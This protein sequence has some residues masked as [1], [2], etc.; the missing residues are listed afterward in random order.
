M[1]RRDLLLTGL[2][3]CALPAYAAQRRYGIGPKGAEISY[4]FQLQGSPVTGRVPLSSADLRIDPQDLTNS[5]A[6]VRADIRRARTGL[7]FAT[8]ALKS[9][10]VL[11]ANRF[12]EARFTSTRVRLGAD[13]R[14]SGGASLEGQL[15]LRGVKRQ[16]RLSANIYRPRGAAPDDLTNLTVLL[17]GRLDRTD[18]GA[19]GYPDLVAKTVTLEIRADIA[20]T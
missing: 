17:T 9:P 19:T 6:D 12:P 20:A 13:G 16:I 11:D 8:Q 5:S 10:A 14:L 15:T 1:H 3:A 7:V 18:F 4:T 2:V